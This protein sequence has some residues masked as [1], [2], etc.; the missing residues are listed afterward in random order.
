MDK[1]A[2]RQTGKKRAFMALYCT[3][4]TNRRVL[5]CDP[6]NKGRAAAC[7]VRRIGAAQT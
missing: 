6:S 1:T 5:V 3:P 2:A 7:A 4:G